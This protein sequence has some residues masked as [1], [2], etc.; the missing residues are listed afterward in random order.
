MGTLRGRWMVAPSVWY[1]V[2]NS[3]S[4]TALAM[5]AVLLFVGGGGGGSVGGGL[6]LDSALFGCSVF[7]LLVRS[8]LCPQ[9]S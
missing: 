6:L 2:P 4:I 5:A 8:A 9:V 1:R 3:E 7:S